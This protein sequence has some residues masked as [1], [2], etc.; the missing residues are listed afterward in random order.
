MSHNH[1]N[2]DGGFHGDERQH[3]S[4]GTQTRKKPDMEEIRETNDVGVVKYD[5]MNKASDVAVKMKMAARPLPPLP[6]NDSM[7]NRSLQATP[8]NTTTT[9]S[10]I[11][12]VGVPPPPP[13]P[14]PQGEVGVPPP[15][16]PPTPQ[17]GVGVPPPPP[18]PPPMGGVIGPSGINRP[19][20]KRVN[21]DK[22]QGTNLE[23]TIWRE[24]R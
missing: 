17:G 11:P 7:G 20:T 14:T 3:V 15:P 4:D 8:T 10:S 2:G 9:L 19:K 13:P 23:G 16:P 18:P 12:Q 21:W 22:I 24:V 1:G 5:T 6:M